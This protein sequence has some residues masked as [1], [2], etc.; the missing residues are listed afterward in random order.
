MEGGLV[1]RWGGEGIKLPA[2]T[3]FARRE[4]LYYH[5]I[6]YFG[7]LPAPSLARQRA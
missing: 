1:D 4:S 7:E 6:D 5:A 2:Q 3:Q